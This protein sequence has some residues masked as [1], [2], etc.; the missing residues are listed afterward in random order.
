MS[1]PDDYLVYPH[2]QY[3]MDHER[4]EWSD[5]FKRPKVLWPN[6]A[7][8]A[9]WV[10]PILQW[11]PLTSAEAPFRAPGGLTMPYPDLRHYTNRD[12]GNRVGIFRL[13]ALLKELNIKGSVA[14]NSAIAQR[15]P[16]LVQHLLQHDMEWIAHGV[17]MGTVHYS[18][19]KNEAEIIHEAVTSLRRI[20]GQP[21]QGWLSPGRS[22]S[23]ETMDLLAQQGVQYSCDWANDDL[24]YEMRVAQGKHYSMPLAFETDDRVVQLEL[25]QTPE[26]W[27]Q[28][29]KDRFDVLWKES[30]QYGGRVMSVPLHA[31]VS[32]VPYRLSA[33]REVLEY[34]MQH[35]GV[36]AANGAEILQAFT[37][38]KEE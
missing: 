29:Q 13:L 6:Q 11:F 32:G 22:Q 19:M 5:L 26:Q 9:L 33:V 36:W 4:Y 34:I 38:A 10:M 30:L 7:R 2:R 8:V 21:I 35:E 17:D 18:G 31:W 24:P 27:A 20:S 16:E 1:L 23:E 3:G 28:Q 14:I 15:Y 12:Y 37:H 25:F